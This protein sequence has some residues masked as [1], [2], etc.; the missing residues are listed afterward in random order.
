MASRHRHTPLPEGT[1]PFLAG[2]IILFAST[3]DAF[4]NV[5]RWLM[6]GPHEGPTYAVHTG[7]FLDARRVLEMEGVARITTLDAVLTR[8]YWQGPLR[9]LL[10]P[11]AWA[12]LEATLSRRYQRYRR[13]WQGLWKPR[14]F[15]VWR[16]SALTAAQRQALTREALTY[17]NVRFGF[18]KF[19]AH[20]LD[21]VI[22][23]LLHRD[24]FLFRHSDPA[25]QHPVCSGITAAVYDKVLHYRFGVDPECADPDHIYDWV[26]AHPDTWVRVFCRDVDPPA[27]RP[28]A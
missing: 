20:A 18:L 25:D 1:P 21:N 13:Y 26:H 7:Q 24:V 14:G 6:R 8:R 5:G 12:Q 16:C 15:E 23:K 19:T 4:S 10:P 17:V 2:D 28:S 11:P 22:C 27:P 3:G 9:A